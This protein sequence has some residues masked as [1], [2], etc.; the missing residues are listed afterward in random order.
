M[1]GVERNDLA[2][3]KISATASLVKLILLEILT[4]HYFRKL[5]RYR[6]LESLIPARN[7]GIPQQCNEIEALVEFCLEIS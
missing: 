7:F 1:R 2:V 3:F 5:M 4:A 6:S